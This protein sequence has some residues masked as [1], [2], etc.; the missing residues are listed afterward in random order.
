MDRYYTIMIVPEKNKDVRSIKIPRLLFKSLVFLAVSF[1]VVLGILTYDYWN[2]LSQVYENKHLVIENRQ[3]KEQVQLFQSKL[4]T[5]NDDLDRINTFERK[6]RVITGLEAVEPTP[7]ETLQLNNKSTSIPY[8]QSNEKDRELT[9]TTVLNIFKKHKLSWKDRF[10]NFEDEKEFQQNKKTYEEKIAIDFGV[11][12]NNQYANKWSFMTRKSLSMANSYAEFDVKYSIVKEALKETELRVNE[13]DQFLL[14]KDSILKSTPSIMPAIGNL[15][16]AYG[17][18]LSPYAGRIKMHE[19]IDIGAPSGTPIV[20]PA[21]G[22]V[23]FSGAKPGFGNFIQIIHGYGVETIFGHMSSLHVKKG[24]K[25]VRGTKIATV[26]NTGYSTG[27][28]LHYEV[29][30]NGTPVDPIYYILN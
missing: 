1:F 17:P 27:P 4:N 16:S 30:V 13:L 7:I 29:R 10:V 5:I 19:G 21:D 24:E 20:A 28:H 22:V 2:I 3:L 6:L 8:N 11:D 23:T 9:G 12:N 18:R 15:T 26:G 14:N 25:I